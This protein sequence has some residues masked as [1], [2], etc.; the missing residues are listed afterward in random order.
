MVTAYDQRRRYLVHELREMGI[1]CF[2][3]FG[4][5]YIFPSIKNSE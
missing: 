2:E 1:D 4:A 5:F 3:P